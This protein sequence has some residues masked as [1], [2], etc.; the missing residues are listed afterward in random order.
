M[1]VVSNVGESLDGNREGAQGEIAWLAE[2]EIPRAAVTLLSGEPGSGK[3]FVACALAASVSQVPNAQVLFAHSEA[4]DRLRARLA[5][6]GADTSRV[7]PV[8]PDLV[9][10]KSKIQNQK[11]KI[12][13]RLDVLIAWLTGATSATRALAPSPSRSLDPSRPVAPSS[14]RPVD[15]PRAVHGIDLIVIDDLE[16][17]C[18]RALSAAELAEATARLDELARTS[19]AA[20]LAVVRSAT[21]TEGRVAARSLDRLMRAA[22]VV[23]TVAGDREMAGHR[24]LVPLKNNLASQPRGKTFQIVEGR[25]EWLNQAVPDDALMPGSRRSAERTDRQTA[26]MWLVEALALSDIP[27]RLL[28]AQAR[29]CGFS[30]NTILRAAHKMGMHSHKSAFDGCWKYSLRDVPREVV[31]TYRTHP[32]WFT[33]GRGHSEGFRVADRARDTGVSEGFGIQD[34]G[35]SVPQA[36]GQAF[37]PDAAG[38]PDSVAGRSP[39]RLAGCDRRSAETADAGDLRSASPSKTAANVEE[40]QGAQDVAKTNHEPPAP[41]QSLEE[42]RRAHAS[43]GPGKGS[44]S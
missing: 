5:R 2:G 35:F 10:D 18:G 8:A 3:S 1:N 32:K 38:L 33:D 31:D 23:W 4:A 14:C 36:V 26:G 30:R 9:G 21:T 29:Q 43:A 34:S 20:V 11:S 19:G 16:S 44:K 6:A 41:N 40:S 24:W 39:D 12:A 27:S 22:D 37:Q 7:T 42:A 15:P 17:W 25:V 13:Q 28:Y